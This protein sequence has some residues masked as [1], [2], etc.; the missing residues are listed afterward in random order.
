MNYT[1]A[2]YLV[3]YEDRPS[4]TVL[5]PFF[6]YYFFLLAAYVQDVVKK[7][8]RTASVAL[9]VRTATKYIYQKRY[10]RSIRPRKALQIGQIKASARAETTQVVQ[11]KQ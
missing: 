2:E 7:R 11:A 10:G 5:V 8:K 4:T 3:Y 6:N 9:A 1:T